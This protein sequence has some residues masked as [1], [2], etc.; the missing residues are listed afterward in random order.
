[1]TAA[2]PTSNALLLVDVQNDFLPG[3]HLEVPR[4]NEIIPV[5]KRYIARFEREC[6]PIF[7][8]R[9]W[10]PRNHCSFQTEGGLWPVHCVME[11]RGAEFSSSLGLP[12]ST[13][14]ISK[15]NVRDKEAYSGFEGTDLENQLREAGVSCVFVGGLATD[16]CVLNTVKDALAKGFKVMLLRDA[17]RAVN[18]R[19]QDGQKAEEEM[20]HRGAVA[21]ELASAGE[22]KAT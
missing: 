20:L 22:N 7:A 8:T 11:T 3:G 15:G 6:A 17:I 19:P 10:H 18:V 21:L 1:M 9:D 4:G 12:K 13:V 2:S 14:I 16:Y 5:L